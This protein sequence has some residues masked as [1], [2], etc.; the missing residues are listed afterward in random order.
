MFCNS[1]NCQQINSD[2]ISIRDAVIDDIVIDRRNTIVTISYL[3]VENRQQVIRTL[4]MIVS[5]NTVILNQ[6]GRTI[7]ARNLQVGMTVNA[8]VSSA[9]TRSIPPQTRAFQITVVREPQQP[10]RQVLVKTGRIVSVDS[11]NNLFTIGLPW[12][13]NQQMRF[14]VSR[15]TVILNRNGRRVG[16][17]HLMPGM[18]VRVEHSDFQTMSIPPQA[19]AF[20]VQIL[21]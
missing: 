9:M 1:R 20:L 7:S 5:G 6:N 15:D 13:I 21:G 8:L 12:N 18:N 3:V 16:I 11:Q 17:R 10:P 2:V 14:V 19:V 4:S